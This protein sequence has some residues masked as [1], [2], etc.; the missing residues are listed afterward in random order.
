M[1]GAVAG[2]E[3]PWFRDALFAA[4]DRDCGEPTKQSEQHGHSAEKDVEG[5]HERPRIQIA[6]AKKA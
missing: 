5:S 3:R 1:G 4:G 2:R 6:I